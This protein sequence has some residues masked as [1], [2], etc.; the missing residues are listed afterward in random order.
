MTDRMIMPETARGMEY[1]IASY[2][3][4]L[5]PE[6]D[7]VKKAESLAV[8]QTIGTWVP[9]PGITD[10]IREKYMGRV[11]QIFDVPPAELKTDA[12][13]QREKMGYLIRIAYPA[14]NFG[15][16][17]ALMMT[18][19]L[20][21]D[22]STSAQVKL[23]DIE[24]P[25]G[26][27][28]EFPGPRYGIRGLRE[29]FGIWDRPLFLNMIK[30]CTGLTP[31]EGSRIFY[32]TA[33]GGADLI[34]DDELFGNPVYSRPADRVRAFRKA[35]DQ[36][37]EET[38]HRTRYIVNVTCGLRELE[39]NVREAEEDG[40]DGVLF[41]FAILGYSALRWLRDMTELPILG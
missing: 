40:A 36:A 30:P 39:K 38:G 35:A 41:N 7:V 27:L 1:V 9:V 29:R 14:A 4:E 16:D 6:Q 34:K 17:F 13:A 28:R 23:M 33:R 10:E 2:Y 22:A 24:F 21:N 25:D 3:I 19:L 11:V 12:P 15:T 32:E 18:A 37:F 5:A 20:G 26:F 31:E 8:G